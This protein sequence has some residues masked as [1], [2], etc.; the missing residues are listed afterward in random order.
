LILHPAVLRFNGEAIDKK[1]Y[2]RYKPQKNYPDHFISE[3]D[4][5]K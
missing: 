3:T 4:P 1:N 2:K 5:N